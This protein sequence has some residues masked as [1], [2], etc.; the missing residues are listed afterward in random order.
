MTD[1]YDEL[2]AAAEAA[3]P[4]PWNS[5]GHSVDDFDADC[6]M[7]MEWIPNG[8]EDDDDELNANREADAAFIALA[9]PKTIKA[10]LSERESLLAALNLPSVDDLVG[11][12]VPPA[13]PP[14][15]RPITAEMASVILDFI[16]GF[17]TVLPALTTKEG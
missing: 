2:R 5:S 4:G 7:R 13:G 3:T 10:L 12:P 9:N 6:G 15:T 14:F 17:Q 11:L 16:A 1:R 8:A